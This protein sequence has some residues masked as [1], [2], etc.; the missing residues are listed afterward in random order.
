MDTKF[1]GWPHIIDTRQFSREFLESVL[2]PLTLRMERISNH[3]SNND[4]KDKFVVV[5]FFEPSTRT[6]FS[7]ELAT[8]LSG[9]KVAQT[10]CAGEFSSQ[11][12]G[13]SFE[14]TIRIL[15]RYPIHAIILRHHT[16]GS[17][18][19]AIEISRGIP[20]VNAGDGPGQHPTQALLDI[21]TIQ[22]KIG[23]IDGISIAM[24]GDLLHGRTVRSLAYLLG[25]FK[26]VKIYFVAP[27]QAKMK[28][29]I[30]DYLE[31]KSIAFEETAD[32][33]RVANK[34][35]VI[36][37][38]RKQLERDTEDFSL[39][40]GNGSYFIVDQTILDLMKQDAIIMHPLPR[41]DEISPEVDDDKRAAYFDQ[42]A[43]G[44]FVRMAL[45]RLIL[46]PEATR[47]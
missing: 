37:Q 12:K 17:A 47:L 4:L 40:D 21:Y 45:L 41:K 20:I 5:L 34:V 38:T 26:D 16:E 6:R 8:R 33:R 11:V 1:E 15:S 36:Y 9:G 23:Q 44:L 3:G 28:Q 46:T 24:V 43:N 13:E 18:K 2:F 30:K 32:L 29:D 7:F 19:R 22:K 27:E 14:D 31:E 10:E 35:N 42:A 39:N 25:K